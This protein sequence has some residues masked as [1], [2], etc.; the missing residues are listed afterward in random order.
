VT[1]AL[2]TTLSRSGEDILYAPVNTEE[3]V[4]LSI[5]A[6]RYYGL[7]SVGTRIW[8]LLETPMT[9]AQICARLCGEFEVEA[10]HCQTAVLKFANELM[11]NGLVH[12]A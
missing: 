3:S 7:N 8:E 1:I 10:Q 4:M 12:A 5:S 2:E 11:R 6:S 9:V